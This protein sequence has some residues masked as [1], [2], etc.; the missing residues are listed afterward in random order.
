MQTDA[1][2]CTGTHL[3]KIAERAKRVVAEPIR[4]LATPNVIKQTVPYR[5]P[6]VRLI[7]MRDS[8][9]HSIVVDA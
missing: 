1:H 4:Q 3:Q 7:A 2:L 8:N 6:Q 5:N 9:M